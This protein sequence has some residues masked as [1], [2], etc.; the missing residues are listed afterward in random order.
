MRVIR[1]HVFS[2]LRPVLIR[3]FAMPVIKGRLC[4]I[5]EC[6]DIFGVAETTIDKWLKQ[7]CP[8]HTKGGRNRQWEINTKEVSNWLREREAAASGADTTTADELR[9]RKLAAETE[10]AELDLALARGDVIKLDKVERA[11]VN[12]FVE[13]RTRIRSAP[14]R[15]GQLLLGVD[16][17][18]RIKEIILAEVDQALEAFDNFTLEDPDN[19]NPDD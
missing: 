6:A 2:F 13:F 7:G 17:E 5:R 4:N 9:K 19:D 14:Q 3:A 12:T 11:L 1:D 16:D 15:C 18:T 10:R 8:Y